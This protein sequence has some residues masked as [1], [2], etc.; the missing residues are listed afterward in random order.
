MIL[1]TQKL[2]LS[3]ENSQLKKHT[4]M[5][6]M[7]DISI[8]PTQQ[9]NNLKAHN[10]DNDNGHFYSAYQAVQNTEQALQHT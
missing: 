10:N 9:I 2:N 5:I 4:K 3:L 1:Y 6:M 7:I 8:V